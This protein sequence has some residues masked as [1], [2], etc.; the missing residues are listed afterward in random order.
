MKIKRIIICLILVLSLTFITGCKSQNQ[1][2]D[3]I[4]FDKLE[5]LARDG[6]PDL[7]FN[8]DTKAI[9]FENGKFINCLGS[10]L[11][12]VYNT[13]LGKY[14]L[15]NYLTNAIIC[16]NLASNVSALGYS[17][18]EG[19][20]ANSS[21]PLAIYSTYDAETT[22]TTVNFVDPYGNIISTFQSDSSVYYND[23]HIYYTDN[24]YVF[25]FGLEG[26]SSDDIYFRSEYKDCKYEVTVTTEEIFNNP[27]ED[28]YN[29]D[30]N[31]F[32]D[33]LTPLYNEKGKIYAYV[34]G[35]SDAF[36]IYDK[37][38][39]YVNNIDLAGYGMD[40]DF[41]IPLIGKIIFIDEDVYYE[42][43]MERSSEETYKVKCLEVNLKTGATKYTD[44]FKYYI[45]DVY[46]N[47]QEED[48]QF[49]YCY[50]LFNKLNKNGE[51]EDQLKCAFV[52]NN[53][54]FNNSFI[55]DGFDNRVYKLDKKTL[56]AYY[57]SQA[58]V[59]T[60]KTRNELTK[61]SIGLVSENGD[62]I[63]QNQ[64][65]K[66]YESNG[67]DFVEAYQTFEKG[68]DYISEFPVNGKR[69]KIEAND[70]GT[71]RV[72]HVNQWTVDGKYYSIAQQG[73]FVVGTK[74]YVGT[75]EAFSCASGESIQSVSVGNDFG[76]IFTITITTSEKTYR[77]AAFLTK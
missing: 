45:E 72:D 70:D 13:D 67:K 56:I 27:P 61:V 22:K 10:N 8:Y 62:I 11:A 19:V 38:K 63:Y 6:E 28:E 60:K 43:V 20:C 25:Y 73:V 21:F 29:I 71:Y 49:K 12:V 52:K 41:V 5:L 47:D 51:K 58:F 4:P 57:D 35:D 69:I 18:Y 50:V 33:G 59:V 40:V 24:D 14:V 2:K 55:Y 3:S 77:V 15:Q 36:F 53:L 42:N 16:Q 31:A 75:K 64:N 37:N 23:Y 17:S 34:G 74:V 48:K 68:Y 65:G 46:Y 7:N 30:P 9:T 76:T 1:K 44:H 26:Y 39:K 54:K 66:Y 32:N